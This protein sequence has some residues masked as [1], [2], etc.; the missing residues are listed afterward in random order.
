MVGGVV[1]TF[2]GR[3]RMDFNVL[4]CFDSGCLNLVCF[5]LL[6]LAS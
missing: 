4:V 3:R 5:V 1:T 2:D 6:L